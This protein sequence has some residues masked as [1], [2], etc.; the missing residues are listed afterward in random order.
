[1][2]KE[3]KTHNTK[4]TLKWSL[5][6]VVALLLVT[7]FSLIFKM[8]TISEYN[9][10]NT[11]VEQI[12]VI[13]ESNESIT[14]ETTKTDETDKLINEETTIVGDDIIKNKQE[15]VDKV[16]EDT[17]YKKEST[18]IK[19]ETPKKEETK[20]DVKIEDASGTYWVT[21]SLNVR[22]GPGT[23]YE[24]IGSLDYGK[25]INITG[26][27]DNNWMRIK[28]NNKD[29][30]VS[31]KYLSDKEIKE[32]TSNSTFP[33]KYSDST[34]TIEI[35]KEWYENAYCY[36][37]HITF[38]DYDRLG[39]TCGKGVYGGAETTSSAAKRVG[40]MFAVNGCY[41]APN[42]DYAVAR[43]GVVYND[44]A[45]YSPGVYNSNTG[46]L[47]S[48]WETGGADGYKGVKL[49]TLVNDGKVT[50][51]FCFGPPFLMNGE[52]KAGNDGSRAQ[53][54][55]IGTNG[56][57]GDIWIVVS[58]GRKNDG[59]SSGLTG[60]QCA[61][62]LKDK[63]CTLGIPLDGGGSSTMVWNGKVLNANKSQRKVVDFLYFK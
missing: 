44:K 33:I 42:L 18:E 8:N 17:E 2:N 55:F 10:T 60:K 6:L 34:A 50:D 13:E 49:S 19:E 61:Q 63:G 16:E 48:A 32:E 29:G 58:D 45:C 62:Y 28:Y 35:T 31:G 14:E 26:K 23:S 30:F 47:L 51:T 7:V 56:N 3:V 53:R 9:D 54:T 52:I 40:A 36:A 12:G 1:M 27:C 24:T 38:T 25:K 37:A 15:S 57:V 21:A 41:S 22:S 43:D 20:P 46:E 11:K 4:N 59:K 5:L 39:T